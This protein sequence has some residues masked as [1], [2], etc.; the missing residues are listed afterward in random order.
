MQQEPCEHVWWAD[1][2]WAALRGMAACGEPLRKWVMTCR[3]TVLFILPEKPIIPES[4]RETYE[5]Q[6]GERE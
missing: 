5:N 3:P 6:T 4:L 1:E 2:M